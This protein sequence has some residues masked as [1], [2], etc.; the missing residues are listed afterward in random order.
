MEKRCSKCREIRHTDEFY[1]NRSRKDGRMPYCKECMRVKKEI[2]PPQQKRC[3][4]CHLIK[5]VDA[6]GTRTKNKD[7]KS[8]R[9]KECVKNSIKV[10]KRTDIVE[11]IYTL[12]LDGQPLQAKKCRDCKELKPL[13]ELALNTTVESGRDSLCNVCK[14]SRQRHYYQHNREK[15]LSSTK[16]WVTSNPTKVKQQKESWYLK[17]KESFTRYRK[18]YYLQNKES[19]MKRMSIHNKKRRT[20][21]QKLPFFF[22]TE[23]EEQLR[24]MY[25]HQCT[26][27]SD[28]LNVQIEHFI[29]LSWGHGGTYK[30]NLYLLTRSLNIS[31]R[32]KNPFEWIKQPHVQQQVNLKKW[33]E[34]IQRLADEHHLTTEEFKHYVYWCEKNK[35]LPE[36]ISK[37]SPT[38]FQLWQESIQKK[39]S[40]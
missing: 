25:Q 16:K 1:R 8:G 14:A 35:R 36:T 24:T 5:S 20:M 31:K 28:Q 15:V 40:S 17:N 26:L 10:G 22:T 30:S 27:T 37:T 19:E 29:P 13:A 11:K 12:L 3:S 39:Q 38:S 18:K 7:G 2:L 6:F 32:D 34:L 33:K 23:H 4:S 21:K 9:C